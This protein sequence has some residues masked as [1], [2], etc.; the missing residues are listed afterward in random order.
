MALL[1][2][3]LIVGANTLLSRVLGYG[4]DILIARGL[5]STWECG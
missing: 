3:S 1:R 5:G 2:S 4:R